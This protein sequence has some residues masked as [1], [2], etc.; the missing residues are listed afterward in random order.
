MVSAALL[1]GAE[2]GGGGIR[3][4]MGEGQFPLSGTLPKKTENLNFVRGTY[5]RVFGGI[6]K[7]LPVQRKIEKSFVPGFFKIPP[8]SRL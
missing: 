8:K 5:N 3:Y 7:N 6:L 2:G 4:K 1:G